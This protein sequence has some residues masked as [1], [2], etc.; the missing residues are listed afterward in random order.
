[1][2][3]HSNSNGELVRLLVSRWASVGCCCEPLQAGAVQLD[4]CRLMLCSVDSC[5]TGGA[6]AAASQQ[7][8]KWI[9]VCFYSCTPFIFSTCVLPFLYLHAVLPAIMGV[10]YLR[11]I[12]SWVYAILG[13]RC[14][15]NFINLYPRHNYCCVHKQI[16]I[17]R[18]SLQAIF[19]GYSLMY[20]SLGIHLLLSEQGILPVVVYII[21]PSVHIF[22]TSSVHIQMVYI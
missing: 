10:R 21:S 9:R 6:V 15:L 14:P 19:T 1:M 16:S 22:Y 5:L 4:S 2:C 7:E 11:C 3:T 12:G 20:P 18:F 13:V 8:T 17:S